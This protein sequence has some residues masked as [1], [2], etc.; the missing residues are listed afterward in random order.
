MFRLDTLKE[1]VIV[2]TGGSRGIGLASAKLFHELGA[3]IILGSRSI[4]QHPPLIG[5]RVYAMNVDVA[6]EEDVIR[7]VEETVEA[8]GVPDILINAAGV[9]TFS[10]ALDL[11]SKDFNEMI[12]VNLKGTFYC[13]KYFAKK[14]LT[15]QSGQMINIVSIAGKEAIPGCAG[16]SASKFG[17][18][19]LTKVLQAE[20][21]TEGIQVTALLPGAVRSTFWDGMEQTPDVSK[22]IPVEVLAQHIVYLAAQPKEASIDEITIMPPLGIL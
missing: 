1:K 11:E 13:C 10:N 21:R 8:A 14:M 4:K 17:V 19:G 15:K 3:T 7:F 22:M 2:I 20:L 9:G 12:D 6:N 16:Y 5:E 18:L